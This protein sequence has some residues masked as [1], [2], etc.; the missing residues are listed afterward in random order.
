MQ[1]AG[2]ELA[3]DLSSVLSAEALATGDGPAKKN[4]EV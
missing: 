4:F 2:G 3:R 1:I